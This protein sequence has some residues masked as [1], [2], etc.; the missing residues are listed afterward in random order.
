VLLDNVYNRIGNIFL[1]PTGVTAPDYNITTTYNGAPVP[2]ATVQL[3]PISASNGGAFATGGTGDTLAANNGYVTSLQATTDANGLAKFT[4]ALLAVGAAYKVQVLPVAFKQ[5]ISGA[6][7]QLALYNPTAGPG[8]APFIAGLGNIDQHIA[9][10]ALPPSPAGVPLY[11]TSATNAVTGSLQANGA[12]VVTFSVPVSGQ[13]IAGGFFATLNPG[14]K[15][16]GTAGAGVLNATNPV[17]GSLSADGLTM[18]MTANYTGGGGVAPA[19]NERGLAITYVEGPPP[20]AAAGVTFPLIEAKDYPGVPFDLFTASG[21]GVTQLRTAS[22]T[23]VSGRVQI[24][25]P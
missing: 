19:G 25:A 22:G 23:F 7:I 20:G 18:T 12:L 4:G 24:V 2:G 3:D 16:D 5:P 6:T 8:S 9:L 17:I 1:F 13:S 10:S 11:V 21:G 14:T 15:A